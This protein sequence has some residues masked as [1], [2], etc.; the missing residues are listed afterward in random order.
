MTVATTVDC[1]TAKTG[2]SVASLPSIGIIPSSPDVVKMS[3]AGSSVRQQL[4]SAVDDH[5]IETT[6][7]KS[8]A[9]EVCSHMSSVI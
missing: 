7:L 3:L 5:G 4:S 8:G 9:V 6:G 1:N 2:G